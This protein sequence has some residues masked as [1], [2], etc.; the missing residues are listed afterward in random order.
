MSVWTE[1]LVLI[2]GD[3]PQAGV[4]QCESMQAVIGCWIII[5]GLPFLYRSP[6]FST[7]SIPF[8]PFVHLESF[9]HEYT[10]F[11]QHTAAVNCL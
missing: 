9:F 10:P 2:Q 7:S 4:L 6:G 1:A 8:F 3:A 5:Q 11:V